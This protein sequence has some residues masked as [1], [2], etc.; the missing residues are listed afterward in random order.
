MFQVD[1]AMV[2]PRSTPHSISPRSLNS[3]AMKVSVFLFAILLAAAILP[4]G[5][6]DDVVVTTTQ[7]PPVQ[8]TVP[9]DL[10]TN[11]LARVR[12]LCELGPRDALTPGAEAAAK[13]IVAELSAIGLVPNTDTFDDPAPDG[14]SRLFRNVMATVPG[15]GGGQ[16]LLLSHYDTKTGISDTFVGANDGGSSTGLLL[17]LAAHFARNPATPSVTFAF[18]DGEECRR[19]YSDTDG[20]HGSR[21]LARKLREAGQHIDAVILLDMVGDRDLRLTLPR[22]GA[23]H[24]KTALLDAAAAQ[25][26]RSKVGLLPYDMVD[27]HVPFLDAGFSAIDLIDFE[28]GSAPGLRDYW[29]TDADTID[30]L[31]SESLHV[32]G[33]VVI[34]LINDLR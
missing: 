13:W 3:N 26:V 15:T 19:A 18:L 12:R 11:A 30:K 31:S 10:G 32:T 21:H 1:F 23:A 17:E 29:H 33:T 14:T 2:S 20:L 16:V 4:V 8:V 5:C 27:D 28:Y 9:A 6:R 22:N 25:G 34:Q 24:L 7:S